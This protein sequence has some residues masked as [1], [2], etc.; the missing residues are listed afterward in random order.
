MNQAWLSGSWVQV[1]S[2]ICWGASLPR[3]RVV[4]CRAVY[5][6]ILRCPNEIENIEPLDVPPQWGWGDE[7]EPPPED[8]RPGEEAAW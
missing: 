2:L 7:I 8:W 4:R 5:G 1:S 3:R 6:S